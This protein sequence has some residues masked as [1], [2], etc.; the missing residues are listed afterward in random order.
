M[1]TP[2]PTVSS[3]KVSIS[4]RN[5]FGRGLYGKASVQYGQYAR[6]FGLTFVDPYFLGYRVAFGL[7]IFGKQQLPTN[8]ISYSTTTVGFGTRLGFALR[9]DVALQLRYGLY[10]QS[11][12]LPDY[13]NDCLLSPN[14]PINGGPGVPSTFPNLDSCFLNGEASLAVRRELAN[15][16]V[17]T[18]SVGYSLT[19]NGVDNNRAPTKGILAELR[20]DFAGVGGDVRFVRTAANVYGYHEVVGDLVGSLHLQGGH[21]TGWGCKNNSQSLLDLP[22]ECLRMLPTTSRWAQSRARIC[23]CRHRAARPVALWPHRHGRRT[24]RIDV[25]GRQPRSVKLPSISFPGFRR[26]SQCV[27]RCGVLVELCWPDQLGSHR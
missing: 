19:Y 20:Q 26:Q 8:Y 11:V 17:L 12:S 2:Q 3:R 15:G 23:P 7:D 5:L 14:A 13:L 18:S 24:G 25:L 22:A 27:C 6:G 4:E 21:I 9:E 10:R 16:P 1:A